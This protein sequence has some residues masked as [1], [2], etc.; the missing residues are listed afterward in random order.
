MTSAI[1][2]LRLAPQPPR[3]P[4]HESHGEEVVRCALQ[5]VEGSRPHL[6]A[7]RGRDH[8]LQIRDVDTENTFAANC[9]DHEAPKS[10]EAIAPLFPDLPVVMSNLRDAG[11]VLPAEDPVEETHHVLR[12]R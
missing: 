1:G 9:F 6:G 7:A 10:D 4:V 2:S 11:R 3:L 5:Q 12:E 8:V